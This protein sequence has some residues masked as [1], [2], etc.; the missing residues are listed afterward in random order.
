MTREHGGLS[1]SWEVLGFGARAR[2][3]VPLEDRAVAAHK[4]LAE[5]EQRHD[6]QRLHLQPAMEVAVI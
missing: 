6:D 3:G 2:L 1:T 5:H 4:Q